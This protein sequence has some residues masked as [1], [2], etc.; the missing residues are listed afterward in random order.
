MPLTTKLCYECCV[1][2]SVSH[3]VL[4][5]KQHSVLF[6]VDF[7]YFHFQN[8]RG[9][10]PVHWPLIC[11]FMLFFYEFWFLLMICLIFV[12]CP[13]EIIQSNK[14]IEGNFERA[15]IWSVNKNKVKIKLT[16]WIGDDQKTTT[17]NSAHTL[18]S[19]YIGIGI[20]FNRDET[21]KK[22]KGSKLVRK[23][24]FL[25]NCWCMVCLCGFYFNFVFR[26]VRRISAELLFYLYRVVFCIGD[27]LLVIL[28][29]IAHFN[30]TNEEGAEE[31]RI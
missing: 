30:K 4:R 7:H 20:I 27:P 10:N 31:V 2:V 29:Q 3:F 23:Y 11:L 25:F 19:A 5:L 9:K 16:K 26:S 24:P 6:S 21:E 17:K 18:N 22:S 12:L 28:L 14:I 13:L 8:R 1:Y 15:Q